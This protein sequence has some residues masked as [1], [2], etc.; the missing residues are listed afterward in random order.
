MYVPAN[1]TIV[2]ASTKMFD[3][4]RQCGGNDGLL[5]SMNRDEDGRD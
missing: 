3:D 2:F 1:P 4:S 5:K